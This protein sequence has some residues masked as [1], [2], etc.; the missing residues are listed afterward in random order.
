[1][2]LLSA[3]LQVLLH[4]CSFSDLLDSCIFVVNETT[5]LFKLLQ[6]HQKAELLEKLRLYLQDIRATDVSK[7]MMENLL[8]RQSKRNKIALIY[9]SLLCLF[10]VEHFLMLFIQTE[11]K[12]LPI[13]TWIPY[14]YSKF[15]LYYPTFS[16]QIVVV[17][18]SALSDISLDCIYYALIDVVCCQLDILIYYFKALNFSKNRDFIKTKLKM[19]IVYH[20]KVIDFVKDIEKLYSNIIFSELLKSLIEICFIGFRL[21]VLDVSSMEF[22]MQLFYFMGM[23]CEILCYCWFGEILTLKSKEIGDACYMTPWNEFDKELKNMLLI[24]IT[25]SQVPLVIRAGF[26]KL[27]LRTLT[28]V[29]II[30]LG[31]LSVIYTKSSTQNHFDNNPI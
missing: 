7:R 13:M 14:D 16:F 10:V 2:L 15:S 22:F 6:I 26:M 29:S 19:N 20:Q 11:R 1:M 25:R 24:M 17:S 21:T 4:D 12:F 28:G 23:F 18:I 3:F 30:M 27:S 31:I 5:F 9:R 8:V